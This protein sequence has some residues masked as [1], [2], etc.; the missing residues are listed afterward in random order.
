[1]GG[2]SKLLSQFMRSVEIQ[3]LITFADLRWSQ[4]HLY[5]IN[6]FILD[7]VLPI[8]YQYVD[9]EMRIHKFNFRHK[10]LPT[11]LLNYDPTI[12]ETANTA[13]NGF[14]QIYDCGKLRYVWNRPNFQQN[15]NPLP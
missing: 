12:S 1:V 10:Y 7:R 8:D 5:E 6:G 14:Y 9:G 13:Q 11:K 3:Q 4:G 15:L 2:F